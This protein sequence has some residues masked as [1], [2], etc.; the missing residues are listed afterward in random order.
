MARPKRKLTTKDYGTIFEQIAV[1]RNSIEHVASLFGVSHR[2]FNLWMESNSKLRDVVDKANSAKIGY[3]SS[4]LMDIIDNDRHH[5]QLTAI[6][7][8][9]KTK[10]GWRSADSI[11]KDTQEAAKE[12]SEITSEDRSKLKTLIKLATIDG[13]VVKN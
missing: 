13:E 4:K 1:K 5:Q 3:V 10:G 6:I 12:D 11:A 2:T 7:F 8:F 9:L